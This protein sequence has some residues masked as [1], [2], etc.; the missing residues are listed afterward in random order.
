MTT[1]KKHETVELTVTGISFGGP[2]IARMDD[3]VIFVT[4]A[5]PG[6]RVEARILKTKKNYAEARVIRIMQPSADR[7]PAPCPHFGTCGGCVWQDVRYDAQLEYKRKNVEDVF[8][9]IGGIES[10]EVPKPVPSP[11]IYHYRNKMEFTFGDRPWM[12][13]EQIADAGFKPDAFALGLHVPQRFD[14]VLPVSRCLLQP[15]DANRVLQVVSEFTKASGLPPYSVKT[16]EG[17]WRFLVLRQSVHTSELMVI[18]ITTA[19]NKPV[20]Q[21]LCKAVLNA[22]P[23]ATGF[24]HGISRKKA[25]IAFSDIEYSLYGPP[26]LREKIF[27]HLYEIAPN[28]FFQTNTLAA[29]QLYQTALQMTAITPQDTVW[30]LY[31]GTGTIAI[32]FSQ[33]CREV[34]G[35]E[36]VPEAVANARRNAER[37]R[38]ANCRF[39]EGEMRAVLR[40]IKE[41]PALTIVDPPRS[42][43][44]ED[45]IEALLRAAPPNILYIS[46]NPATQARDIALMTGHYRIERI[47]PVDMFPHTAHIENIVRLVKK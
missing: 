36:I 2:G 21:A 31:S 9:R 22:A 13:P 40:D 24:I 3:Y 35:I 28:A 4:G 26:V 11:Q 20:M 32:Y 45:V 17:F 30:D 46:C 10:P 37:N 14:K 23:S 16:H 15:E 43:L 29:E 41:T 12:A 19:E 34:T 6:D 38:V 5:I 47:Q 18:V 1:I 25:Q 8:T 44:H 33:F 42:G 39:I 7:V 27:N